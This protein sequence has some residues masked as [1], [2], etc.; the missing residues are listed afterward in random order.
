MESSTAGGVRRLLQMAMLACCCLWVFP[1]SADGLSSKDRRQIIEVVQ[2]QL[3]AF[4]QDDAVKAFSY[5]APKIRQMAGNAENFFEMVRSRYE[6]VYRPASAVFMRPSGDGDEA[7]LH[8][9]MTDGEG[10]SWIATYALQRQK[11][12]SWRIAGCMLNE[13][14]GTMV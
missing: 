6:V 9:R 14:T 11:N 10:T 1:A 4:A 3:N 2:G 7:V 13:A 5:A 8:V 12:R